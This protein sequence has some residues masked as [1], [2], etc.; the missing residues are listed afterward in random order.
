MTLLPYYLFFDI[1]TLA[2]GVRANF[3][4]LDIWNICI[5]LFSRGLTTF[6]Q[7]FLKSNPSGFALVR[8]VTLT[9]WRQNRTCNGPPKK[10]SH[11][12]IILIV[13]Y[14]FFFYII[15]RSGTYYF[16]IWHMH[17]NLFL[18]ILNN[19]NQ[20]FLDNFDFG[21][22]VMQ[23]QTR[24]CP[25]FE[26]GVRWFVHHIYQPFT[27]TYSYICFMHTCASLVLLLFAIRFV[28]APTHA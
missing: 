23:L 9:T 24:I 19:S 13:Y 28:V 15:F 22:N 18:S 27:L 16:S 7:R 17:I 1:Q 6:I 14:N 12:I 5:S 21:K 2:D 3:Q 20:Y 26:K 10:I 8:Q 4:N 11:S 25:Y